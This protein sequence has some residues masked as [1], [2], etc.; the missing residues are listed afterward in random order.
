MHASLCSE[1][2]EKKLLS[3]SAWWHLRNALSPNSS[4]LSEGMSS[5]DSLV[6]TKPFN[7]SEALLKQMTSLSI[8]LKSI[9]SRASILP[10]SIVSNASTFSI[11]H[12]VKTVKE[13]HPIFNVFN[14]GQF[15]KTNS[16]P[17][18]E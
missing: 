17:G 3:N 13:S 16:P 2:G 18:D 6:A 11:S 15:F 12:T 7:S 4:D 5:R 14:L 10:I 9:V 8:L 1:S